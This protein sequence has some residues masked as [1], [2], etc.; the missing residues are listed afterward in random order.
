VK[1]RNRPFSKRVAQASNLAPSLASELLAA[2]RRGVYHRPF[3][4]AG[5]RVGIAVSGGADSV[6]LL[7]LLL[8]LQPKLGV[9]LAA[10][11]FNHQLRG[12]ASDGDEK[13]VA[14]L[15]A[16]YGLEFFV[17]RANIRAKA[18]REKLN[19]E[20]AARRARYDF[21]SFLVSEHKLT[22]VAVAHTADD[23]AETVLA[24]ILRGTG[25]TGLAGIHPVSNNGNVVRPLLQIRHNA[26]RA[27]LKQRKQTWREDATNH[28]TSKL[29]ARIRKNLIPLLERRF[30]PAA[31]E[32]LSALA[33]RAREDDAQL[34]FVAENRV[35]ALV[36]R[37]GETVRM[38][39]NELQSMPTSAGRKPSE[40]DPLLT[41]GTKS[42]SRR[43]ARHIVKEVKP[44]AG[45]LG[46]KHVE[47]ILD[48][49]EFGANG[50]S[51]MLPGGVEVRRERDDLVF[52]PT[53]NARAARKANGETNVAPMRAPSQTAQVSTRETVKQFEENLD[54]A[55]SEKLLPEKLVTVPCLACAF[56]FRNIDW[57][58]KRE[59][60]TSIGSVLDR[61]RLQPPVVLRNWRPG[62]KVQPSGHRKAH[63]LKRLLNEQR[64][65]RWEREGWPVLTSA[66]VIAWARGF[67][68]SVGFAATS[69]TRT[70][71]VI[72]EEPIS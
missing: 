55:A 20:D 65:S 54:F 38:H 31:V 58:A 13:F 7:R 4:R 32:H 8:D 39:V 53:P 16:K 48:F 52:C 11:H 29:R 25:I 60:T 46:A 14:K 35:Q 61:Q 24:H 26:L 44:R 45:E 43:M 23:Q 1:K 69:E 40:L 47:A 34:E 10:V 72:S 18:K 33:E 9:V 21:F 22:C 59:E 57:P 63:K 56:R 12:K 28:D 64:V 3:F 2:I 62:D 50:K 66:G 27:Y 37:D 49:A 36:K 41:L 42:V 68:V 70:A 71:I 51:L 67:P 19:L 6:G 30:Q 15:A 17:A 5:D